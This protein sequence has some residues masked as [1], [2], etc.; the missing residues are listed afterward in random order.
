MKVR[1][2]PARR[3]HA[4]DK[5]GLERDFFPA[6]DLDLR[7]DRVMLRAVADDD[8]VLAGRKRLAEP[9]VVTVIGVIDRVLAAVGTEE[10]IGRAVL[11][12]ELHLAG[13]RASVLILN[14]RDDVS[15]AF[16]F[17][18]IGR[19]RRAIDRKLRDAVA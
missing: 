1:A 3:L 17:G 12:D 18:E 16:E 19:R 14:G 8:L 9:P 15:G 5:L 2:D 11:A 4:P 6:L 7:E 10:R 13:D